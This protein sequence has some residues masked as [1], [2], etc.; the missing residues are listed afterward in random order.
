M[1][2]SY[3]ISNKENLGSVSMIRVDCSGTSTD[4]FANSTP[5][6]YTAEQFGLTTVLDAICTNKSTYSVKSNIT[7]SGFT[8]ES[9]AQVDGADEPVIVIFGK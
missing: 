3:T 6:A 8:L 4:A 7:S 5:V 9:S 2:K 1:A